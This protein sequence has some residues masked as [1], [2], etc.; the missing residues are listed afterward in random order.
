MSISEIEEEARKIVEEAGKK[1][2]EILSKARREAAELKSRSL[3]GLLGPEEK[4]KIVREF[5]LRIK[6]IELR[7]EERRQA[8]LKS[9]AEKKKDLV[10][11]IVDLVM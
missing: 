2:E 8:I 1:A 6:D 9:F 3:V 4:E 11:E 5:E 10:K 7:A